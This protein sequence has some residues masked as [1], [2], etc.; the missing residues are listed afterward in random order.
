M[1]EAK[2]G[3]R[4]V[5]DPPQHPHST[6]F[7]LLTKVLSLYSGFTR[8]DSSSLYSIFSV[9]SLKGKHVVY[10]PRM[11][12]QRGNLD[13]GRRCGFSCSLAVATTIPD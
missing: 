4:E 7:H 10:L 3:S 1:D 9:H 5:G 2:C 13:S 11:A 8:E 6:S 12:E